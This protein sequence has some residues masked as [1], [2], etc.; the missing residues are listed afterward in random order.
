MKALL[1]EGMVCRPPGWPLRYAADV[2][3]AELL[4]REG[5]EAVTS[6]WPNTA[7]HTSKGT[8][9]CMACLVRMHFGLHA[10]PLVVG[11]GLWRVPFGRT[12]AV[13]VRAADGMLP[14]S[15]LLPS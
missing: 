6:T 11:R 1:R 8:P 7:K 14:W 10:A 4:Q 15:Q 9:P 5:A 13:A 3:V 2:Q 12:A